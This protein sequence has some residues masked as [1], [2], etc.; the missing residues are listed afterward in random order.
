M[1]FSFD[2]VLTENSCFLPSTVVSHIAVCRRYFSRSDLFCRLFSS[3][4]RFCVVSSWQQPFHITSFI[5]VAWAVFD[6]A[7]KNQRGC[8]AF[9]CCAGSPA[10]S[11]DH[12]HFFMVYIGVDSDVWPCRITH[13]HLQSACKAKQKLTYNWIPETHE[14]I[15][16]LLKLIANVS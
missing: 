4:H 3:G 10:H 15:N 14:N 11:V 1:H 6:T 13:F 12:L 2:G 8:L 5:F 16:N 9:V 7:K